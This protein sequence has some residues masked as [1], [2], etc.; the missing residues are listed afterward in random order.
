MV[1]FYLK[2]EDLR[3]TNPK[4]VKEPDYFLHK[5]TQPIFIGS[6]AQRMG[7]R[8][9]TPSSIDGIFFDADKFCVW[10]D[11][12]QMPMNQCILYVKDGK[13]EF[14]NDSVKGTDLAK[15]GKEWYGFGGGDGLYR[16]EEI[17]KSGDQIYLG[18][19]GSPHRFRITVLEQ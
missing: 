8:A 1:E 14:H 16:G 11:A 2:F 3:I 17:L 12:P 5:I 7:S 6:A 13:L 9:M 4:K 19:A 15:G 18:F 10:I